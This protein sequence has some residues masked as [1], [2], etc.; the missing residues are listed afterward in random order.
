VLSGNRNF[1]GRVHSCCR[2]NYLASPPLVIAYA[3]A[4]RMTIDIASEPLGTGRDG[5]PVFL[6]DIWPSDDE[7]AAVIQSV[8]SPDLYRERYANLFDG[9]AH[10]KSLAVRGG[11]IFD[12]AH[13]SSYIRRPPFFAGITREPPA[14]RDV[15]GARI[16]AM[17]GDSITTDHISPIGVIGEGSPAGQY[18]SGLGVAKRDFNSYA[19]RRV[20]HDVMVRGT[21]ANI[22]IRNEMMK[23]REGGLTLH[24][25]DRK[26]MSIFD[27]AMA[28]RDS[29]TPLVIVAGSD[30]GTGSS[31]DWAAKGTLLLGVRAIL[32]ESFERIHRS[33][34]IGMGI[35][36]CEFPPGQS[37]RTLS[38]D[39]SEIIDLEGLADLPPRGMIDCRIRRAD[40]SATRMPLIC[41]IDT[42]YELQ[43]FHN[44]GILQLMLRQMLL[45]P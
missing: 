16:L 22:R 37:R 45:S 27:A 8:L 18:L 14:M 13:G 20:N 6:A 15:E 36:P 43:Y 10:W 21:F 29:G 35:L 17:F 40:G 26:E 25:P 41:R 11:D 39:G 1:E 7:I 33:N 42:A 23:G 12:W 44:G 9:D 38:L 19:S 24:M 34:L 31:R 3:L 30:Y 5:A 2:V 32:A 4:G 28:Y